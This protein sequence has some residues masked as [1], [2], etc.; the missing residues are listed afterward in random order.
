MQDW[1]HVVWKTSINLS[2]KV[3]TFNAL[4]TSL[5][6]SIFSLDLKGRATCTSCSMNNYVNCID[7]L[8]HSYWLRWRPISCSACSCCSHSCCSCFF[9]WRRSIISCYET[10]FCYN[11]TA[12]R[13]DIKNVNYGIKTLAGVAARLLQ[14]MFRTNLYVQRLPRE[15]LWV[16]RYYS[17]DKA[18]KTEHW[19]LIKK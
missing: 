1:M 5:K 10:F 4:L 13:L 9:S 8:V 2:F 11:M 16:C 15:S 14:W 19:C 12:A 3:F 6:S 18:F 17:N 7:S